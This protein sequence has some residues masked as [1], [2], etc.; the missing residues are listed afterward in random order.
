MIQEA[1]PFLNFNG[2]CHQAIA[3]Y[4]K[5]LDAKVAD[6]R[7]WEPAMFDGGK[8]PEGMEDGVMYARLMMGEVPLE[9]SDVPPHFKVE[10]GSHLSIN[11]HISDPDELDRRVELLAQGGK[12]EMPPE[13]MF[14]GGRMA[15][16]IDRFGVSW[17]FHCQVTPG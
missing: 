15:K 2:D 11:L 4:Q 17:M 13:T 1:T 9:M 3:L 6:R 10:P 16:V 14:W 7:G 8:V 12:V 5:A